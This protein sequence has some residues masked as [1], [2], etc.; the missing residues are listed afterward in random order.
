MRRFH[1]LHELS[2]S[3]RVEPLNFASRTKDFESG[4]DVGGLFLLRNAKKPAMP[5]ITKTLNPLYSLLTN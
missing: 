3:V 4:F 2:R 5:K 1:S